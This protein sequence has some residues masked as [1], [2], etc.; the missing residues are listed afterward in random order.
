MTTAPP[1]D[2]ELYD[3]ERDTLRKI[4]YGLRLKHSFRGVTR[5]KEEEAIKQAFTREAIQRCAEAGFIVDVLWH[6]EDERTGDM[7]PNVSDDPEDKNLYWNPKVVIA[8]RLDKVAVG[9]FDHDKLKHEIRS[10]LLD[11]KKGEIREN[12]EFREDPKTKN[13]Y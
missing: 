4:I 13:Y 1:E 2:I 8:G 10:G 3:S 6:W 7:S 9:E 11:G 12:G 5:E